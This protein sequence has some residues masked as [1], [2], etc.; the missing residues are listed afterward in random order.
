MKKYLLLTL[1]LIATC[2][3]ASAQDRCDKSKDEMFREVKEFKMKFLAQELKLSDEQCRPFFDLYS[4]Q[5]DE[6]HKLWEPAMELER[7]VK[8]DP[9][10]S[11]ADYNAVSE[12]INKAKSGEA[13]LEGRYDEKFRKILTPKQIYELKDAEN[14]FREKM[15]EMRSKHPGHKHKKK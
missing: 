10:A 1:I 8:K 12:A 11:E 4:A 9:N 3:L 2:G 13:E 7:K 15:R 14:R 5:M 6:R